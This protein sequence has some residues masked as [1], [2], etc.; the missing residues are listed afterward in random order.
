M[1][2]FDQN[3]GHLCQ[4]YAVLQLVAT[5]ETGVGIGRIWN[6]E[7]KNYEYNGTKVNLGNDIPRFEIYFLYLRTKNNKLEDVSKSEATMLNTSI[8]KLQRLPEY[9]DGGGEG[10][11]KLH[12]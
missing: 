9:T 5:N 2:Q 4:N 11:E 6:L 8:R 1:F 3:Y 10:G 7:M 12:V